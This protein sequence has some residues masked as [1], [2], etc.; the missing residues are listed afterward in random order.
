M[1]GQKGP[2][3]VLEYPGGRGGG[4]NTQRYCE[5]V[6]E[7]VVKGFFEEMQREREAIYSFNRTTHH[8]TPASARN[9]G[10]PKIAFHSYSIPQTHLTSP[11]SSW[12]SMSS[13]LLYDID[14]TPL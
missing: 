13:R 5:Q 14:L 8:A 4:M 7:S 2:L 10:F 1:E 3:V 6:L 11:P 9:R 12:Y